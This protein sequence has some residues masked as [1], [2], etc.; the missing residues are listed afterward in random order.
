MGA[1][2]T[3][4]WRR[5]PSSAVAKS[6][7]SASIRYWVGTPISMVTR[8]SAISCS[9]RP[10]SKPRSS[11]TVAPVHQASSG[12]MFQPP[13]WNC[14]STASTTSV[15]PRS[16]V[17][18]SE[19]LVQKQLAWVSTAALLAPSVPDVKIIS[20]GS[21]SR[22]SRCAGVRAGHR[23]AAVRD[24]G[25]TD[26]SMPPGPSAAVRGRCAQQRAGARG[27][28]IQLV[29]DEQ[30]LRG[31]RAPAARRVPGA[32]AART[33]APGPARPW[34]RRRTPPR[35]PSCCRSGSRSGPPSRSRRPRRPAAR[36]A[37]RRSSS[38]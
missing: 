10:G 29:L 36:P 12:W 11:T 19:R 18:D 26:F 34:R 28:R 22:T 32:R 9:T 20:R 23:A 4:A 31:R 8:R 2:P 33:A 1:P 24:G 14:G 16:I 6:G 38:P 30:Q 7:C 17:R 3:T 25:G 5:L 15:L 27:E 35:G 21:S 37:A 13:T